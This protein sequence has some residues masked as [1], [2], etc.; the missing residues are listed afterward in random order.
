[1]PSLA[2]AGHRGVSREKVLSRPKQGHALH[3]SPMERVVHKSRNPREAE[4]WEIVQYR[5]MTPAQRVNAGRLL[6]ERAY[7]PPRP[8]VRE[9]HR[10]R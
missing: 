2:V 3:F 1:M 5:R 10:R 4:A 7:P 8:D 6:K 9:W